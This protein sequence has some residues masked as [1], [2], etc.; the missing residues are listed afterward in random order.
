MQN[1]KILFISGLHRSGT[2]ILHR[3][4]STS[5]DV[6][7][8]ENTGVP[9]DEGQHLQ[10][11]YK[12]A[13]YY[14][15]PGKFAF[16]EKARLDENSALISETNKQK[17]LQEWGRYWEPNKSIWVE[18][19]PPN[20]IRT[21]FFQKL[22]PEALFITIIR[23]PI[24]VACAT[25]KWSKTSLGSLIKHWLKAYD[26]YTK[27]K[28]YLKQE[29]LIS[30]EDMIAHPDEIIDRI[31]SFVNISIHYDNQLKNKNHHYFKRWK[32]Q[33][34]WKIGK[35]YSRKKIIDKYEAAV[36][37]F[38]YSLTELEKY[39]ETVHNAYASSNPGND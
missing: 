19:S 6:S 39:P 23:H 35:K 24:A 32:E 7:G 15:G 27:D 3:I 2:S 10:S 34:W 36:N 28:A 20:L 38:G 9:E 14:G 11:L 17:L 16:N 1:S 12:P 22:F 5:A 4:I 29:L 13:L 31:E 30:Y 33:A 26:I 8:F 25:Q 18:K 21:R 37:S